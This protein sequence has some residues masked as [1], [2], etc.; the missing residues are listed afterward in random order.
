MCLLMLPSMHL[1]L[2]LAAILMQLLTWL[3]CVV[4]LSDWPAEVALI[5]FADT[6]SY[7]RAYRC[8]H[9]FVC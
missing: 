4:A 2:T 3:V 1:L 8:G 9:Q 5:V 7:W 6:T